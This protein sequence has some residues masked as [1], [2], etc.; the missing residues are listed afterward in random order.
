MRRRVLRTISGLGG[1]VAIVTF[2]PSVASAQEGPDTQVILDNIWVFIAGC[3]VFFMQAGFA[4]VE[5]GLTRAK[6]V[7][8]I[9]AK[10]LSDALIGVLCFFAVGYA[11]AF[12][13]DGKLIGTDA[14]FL[15][16]VDGTI[17]D[18]LS[19]YTH[20]LLPGGVR[21]DSGDDR[22]GCDG[23]ADQVHVIPD[24]QCGHDGVHLPGDRPLDVGWRP[25]RR[26][27]RSAMPS[28]P[29]SP[30]RASCT[31]AAGWPR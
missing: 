5:A 14:F 10:N 16:G 19:G 29:T 22:V 8:N 20:V 24:L 3:L 9:F 6:N 2:V 23:R 1:A 17:T 26:D 30:A 7:V 21:R 15:Q 25:D 31:C 12:G 27:Q 4:L 13:G 18:G 11:F 28:T